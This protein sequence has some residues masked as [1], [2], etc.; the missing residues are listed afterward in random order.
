MVQTQ[1]STIQ[2]NAGDGFRLFL[3][4]SRRCKCDGEI[5]QLAHADSSLKIL[6]A[7]VAADTE[8]EVVV[9]NQLLGIG[10]LHYLVSIWMVDPILPVPPDL[11]VFRNLYRQV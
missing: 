3:A 7:I 8:D 10:T 9:G 6:L 2:R 11:L 4:L 1:L 5:K